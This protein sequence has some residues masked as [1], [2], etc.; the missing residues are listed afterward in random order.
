MLGKFWKINIKGK[1]AFNL[2]YG[3]HRF[4][5]QFQLQIEIVISNFK[6]QFE[7]SIEIESG[8]SQVHLRESGS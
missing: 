2:A 1:V 4:Q 8:K 5:I 6:L 7:F 3:L